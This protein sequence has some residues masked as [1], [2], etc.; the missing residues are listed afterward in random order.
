MTVRYLN[1][2]IFALSICLNTLSFAD[3]I[4]L[5][6]L[7]KVEGLTAVETRYSNQESIFKSKF[8]EKIT[9]KYRTDQS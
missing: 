1:I 5:F 4:Q 2:F 9:V 3:E 6:R 8:R 7:K